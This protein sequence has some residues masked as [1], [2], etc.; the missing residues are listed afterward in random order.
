MSD[1]LFPKNFLWGSATAAH[2]VEG[3]KNAPGF[4]NWGSW[5]LSPARQEKLRQ[6]GKIKQD[7]DLARFVTG[8]ACDFRHRYRGDFAA[9]RAFNHNS[10]RLSIDWAEIEPEDGR[11]DPT[12]LQRYREMVRAAREFGLEPVITLYHWTHPGWFEA[13]GAWQRPDAA[14]RFSR[15]AAAVID[16][17][18]A[19]VRWWTILNEPNVYAHFSYDWGLWPPQVTSAEAC[20]RVTE[21]QLAAHDAV[22]QQLRAGDPAA[23]LGIAQSC[24]W[25]QA[26]DPAEKERMDRWHTEFLDLVRGQLDFIGI[27]VYHHNAVRQGQHLDG[28]NGADPC[29]DHPVLSDFNWGMCPRSLAAVAAEL[30]QRYQLPILVTEHGHA[31]RELEDRRRCWFLWQSLAELQ[32]VIAEGVPVLG[33]LHWSLLDN[34][35]WADGYDPCFGLWAVERDAARPTFLERTPRRSAFLLRDIIAAGGLTAALA[36]RYGAAIERPGA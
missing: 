17:I 14:R 22:Y 23:R 13:S 30:H 36:N 35:E 1:L 20:A 10:I 3:G 11:Y 5:E 34:F 15:M 9:A 24:G 33:Y 16:Q 6:D 31:V 18:G 7:G 4:S 2:Q 26:D 8:P 27:N 32:R 29:T 28:W 19:D 25:N 21:Q 12:Q